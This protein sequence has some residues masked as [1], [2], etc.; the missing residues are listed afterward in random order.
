MF[1]F[2][3]SHRLTSKICGII[4]IGTANSLYSFS[5]ITEQLCYGS[6]KIHIMISAFYYQT[7]WEEFV[8]WR[9]NDEKVEEVRILERLCWKLSNRKWNLTWI[10]V[11]FTGCSSYWRLGTEVITTK[12]W[13]F[14]IGF[15]ASEPSSQWKTELKRLKLS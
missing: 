9:H 10:H 13:I 15:M 6:A 12:F 5:T 3:F 4:F 8:E 2:F 7:L 1:F 11:D 14:S